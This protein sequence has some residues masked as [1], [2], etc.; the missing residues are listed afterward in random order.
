MADL[1]D[2]SPDLVFHGGDVTDGCSAPAEVVDIIRAQGWQ[3]VL[4]NTDEMLARPASLREFAES[5]PGIRSMLGAIETLAAANRELLGPD[6]LNWLKSLPRRLDHGA[7]ALVHA[8]ANSAWHGPGTNAEDSAL[9]AAYRSLGRPVVVYGHIHQPFVRRLTGLIV[10]NAGSVGMPYDGDP[11][12]SYLLLDE[13]APTIR[14]VEYDIE[15]EIAARMS[16][17]IPYNEWMVA[18]LRTAQPQPMQ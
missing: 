1:R 5:S 10:V 7:M 6:R 12:A 4:G 9:E 15:K 2:A 17:G 16:S 11:R 13:S 3:G 8:G 18:T 14:R